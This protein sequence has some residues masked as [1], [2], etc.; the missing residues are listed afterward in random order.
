MHELYPNSDDF[1]LTSER[2]TDNVTITIE[3]SLASEM[4]N[5]FVTAITDFPVITLECHIDGT[6]S[7]QYTVETA[8]GSV[9]PGK[10]TTRWVFPDFNESIELSFNTPTAESQNFTVCGNQLNP[11]FAL[12]DPIPVICCEGIR[13]NINSDLSDV[14]DIADLVFFVSYAF[15][16][17]N[18]PEPPCFEE[19]DVDA[20]GAHDIGDLVYMVDYMFDS[21]NGPAPLICP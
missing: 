18:G 7:L 13:G 5:F 19:G 14:I 3:N 11:V 1:V 12:I 6:P 16:S 21:P 2:Q 20:S 15:G 8:S 9:Y 10:F 4:Q 17:P